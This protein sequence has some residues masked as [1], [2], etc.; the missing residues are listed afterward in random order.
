MQYN[1]MI[2]NNKKIYIGIC[3]DRQEAIFELQKYI[4]ED[5]KRRKEDWE[6]RNFSSGG[7]LLQKIEELSI[8][9]LDIEMPD[10]D[11]IET[12]REIL[13]RNPDCRIVM[14]TGI[15]ERF[16]EAFQIR[17][18]RY[19]TKPFVKEE[20]V[21]ALD[22]ALGKVW[23][24]KTIE[25]SLKRISY[26]IFQREIVYVRAINGYTE[27]AV[28]G[29]WMRKDIS[30]EEAV[31]LLDDHVFARVDRQ[32][33]VNLAYVENYKGGSFFLGD[34]KFQVSRRLKKEFEKKYIEYDLRYRQ[35]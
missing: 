16:K 27:Y 30:L 31:K 18:V 5:M 2:M 14:A 4:K 1:N 19:V 21:E 23:E 11:G 25:L 6:I 12:G 29:K 15:V 8:V 7:E 10:L 32:H 3:D 26:Q 20:V 33:I 13:K 28:N 34:K 22:A 35:G 9:F 24:Q 17:A